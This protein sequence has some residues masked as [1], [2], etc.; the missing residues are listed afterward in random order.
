MTEAS[1]KQN[2]AA[3][4]TNTWFPAGRSTYRTCAATGSVRW[5]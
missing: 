1:L 2:L 4:A 3:P 5:A